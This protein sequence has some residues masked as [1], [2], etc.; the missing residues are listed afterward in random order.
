MVE[1]IFL[2]KLDDPDSRGEVANLTRE[3]L[4]DLAGVEELSVGVPA[5]AAAAK[6]WDMSLILRFSSL[7]RQTEV[8]ECAAFKDYL[9]RQ[10][11]GRC[12]VVKAWSF[13]RI[14]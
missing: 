14:P 7:A 10:M 3:A 5:D 9:E 13:E 12:Q 8:L 1:R 11:G 2:F 4:Y 6:S